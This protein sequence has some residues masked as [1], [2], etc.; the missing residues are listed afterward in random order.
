[1]M[2]QIVNSERGRGCGKQLECLTP[3]ACQILLT[4]QSCVLMLRILRTDLGI[5][6][7]LKLPSQFVL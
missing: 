7:Q 6:Y 2:D 3:N 4:V 1:M 5:G